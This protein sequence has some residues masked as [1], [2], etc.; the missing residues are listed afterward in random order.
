MHG[1][2]ISGIGRLDIYMGELAV[3][4]GKRGYRT[5]QIQV[6]HA[7]MLGHRVLI[8]LN[9][10]QGATK[11]QDIRFYIF[12]KFNYDIWLKMLEAEDK[13]ERDYAKPSALVNVPKI[14]RGELIFRPPSNGTYYAVLDNTYSRFMSKTVAM[15]MIETWYE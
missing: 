10:W 8:N 4:S 1:F 13:G 15:K 2:K 14:I 12:D 3:P 9:V 11:N 7:G 5:H 6:E